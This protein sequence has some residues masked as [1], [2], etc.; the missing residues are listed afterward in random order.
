MSVPSFQISK[1][2]ISA[3]LPL[4][5]AVIILPHCNPNF[6]CNAEIRTDL[7]VINGTAVTL[8]CSPAEK[9]V[10]TH[11]APD[12]ESPQL[13]RRL[14]WFQDGSLIASYQQASL[15][16]IYN[17]SSRLNDYWLQ[18]FIQESRVLLP[19]FSNFS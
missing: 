7:T 9:L 5:L 11:M 19:F 1:F 14:E 18:C 13:I 15:N 10:R 16:E 6:F 3:L 12:F 17:F 4:L 8:K 2:I